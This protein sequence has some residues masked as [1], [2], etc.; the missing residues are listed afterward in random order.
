M[1]IRLLTVLGG[2]LDGAVVPMAVGVEEFAY[3]LGGSL[4]IYAV[5]ELFDGPKVR[6]VVRQV[7]CV[8]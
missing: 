4:H 2:P 7:Q 3:R 8:P 6:L 1:A 5:G